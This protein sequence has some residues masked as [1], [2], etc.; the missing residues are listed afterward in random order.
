MPL[1]APPECFA[2]SSV[3][4]TFF[5]PYVGVLVPLKNLL[6][7]TLPG[8]NRVSSRVVDGDFAEILFFW[9]CGVLDCEP[10]RELVGLA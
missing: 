2:V 4:D 1:L 7:E 10:E 6:T 8:E 5:V 9:T 3:N